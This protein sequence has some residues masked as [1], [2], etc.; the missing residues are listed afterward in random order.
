MIRL[1]L[2]ILS[3][4][5]LSSYAQ[6]YDSSFY[7]LKSYRVDSV[8]T[9]LYGI[10]LLQSLEKVTKE[11]D[12]SGWIVVNKLRYCDRVYSFITKV[13]IDSNVKIQ[14]YD[15]SLNMKDS[16]IFESFVYGDYK[17]ELL[18][19][20]F[21]TDLNSS[22]FTV[23]YLKYGIIESAHFLHFFDFSKSSTQSHSESFPYIIRKYNDV[24]NCILALELRHSAHPPEE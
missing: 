7:D 11:N 4:L 21:G 1:H 10:D 13:A 15:E 24:F 8:L 12:F 16:I 22:T 9:N 18:V 6:E 20:Y 3:L 23:L 19:N 2:F 14:I 17:S 5:A